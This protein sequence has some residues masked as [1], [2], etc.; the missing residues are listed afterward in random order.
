[1]DDTVKAQEACPDCG[2]QFV[3][4]SAERAQKLVVNHRWEVHGMKKVPPLHDRITKC[5]RCNASFVG[6]ETY[7]EAVAMVRDHEQRWH[8]GRPSVEG[9]A[10][11]DLP[12]RKVVRWTVTGEGVPARDRLETWTALLA[13]VGHA[14]RLGL[15][16]AVAELE[17]G[18]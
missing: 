4:D 9:L 3:A 2:Q 6:Q 17:E 18:A 13:L 11:L 16:V 7:D 5:S 14:E 12:S 10:A 15:R 8:F 1:M